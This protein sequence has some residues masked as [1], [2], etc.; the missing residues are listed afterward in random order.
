MRLEI[1]YLLQWGIKSIG[2][3]RLCLEQVDQVPDNR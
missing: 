2:C 1:R 3:Q